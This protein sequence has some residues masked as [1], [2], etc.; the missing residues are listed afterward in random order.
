MFKAK[1]VFVVGAGASAELGLPIGIQLKEQISTLL[2]FHFQNGQRVQGGDDLIY[3]AC[4]ISAR[5][6]STQVVDINPYIKAGRTIQR[7]MPVSISIDNCLEQHNDDEIVELMGKL[8]IVRAIL[9]AEKQSALY[10]DRRTRIEVSL[11]NPKIQASW[12]V[13]LFKKLTES[14]P[15]DKIDT[16]FK[17]VSFVIFNYD[18]CVESFLHTALQ[19]AYGIDE[20]RAGKVLAAVEFIH[21]YGAVGALPWQS[22]NIRKVEYGGEVDAEM[23][24]RLATGIRTYSEQAESGEVLERL[25]RCM[26][27]AA[28][29]VYLGFAFH[30]QNMAMLH[31]PKDGRAQRVFG[32]AMGAS[33][34]DRE[35]ISSA[36]RS[37]LNP[38][39]RIPADLGDFACA[40]LFHEYSRSIAQA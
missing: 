40:Q 31:V 2:N 30:P 39:L 7:A 37:S 20:A 13:A 17:D 11:A 22:E 24:R 9:N 8:A 26:Q 23:L 1:T 19:A 33:K 4:Y 16:I 12:Y 28:T 25:H 5:A 35:I 18:R 29:A 14:V 6:K 21:P 3:E 32:T 38:D 10:L 34:S 27:E 36:I 15:R